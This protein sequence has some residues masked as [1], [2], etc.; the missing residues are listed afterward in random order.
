VRLLQPFEGAP[1]GAQT[2]LIGRQFEILTVVLF[3]LTACPTAHETS[4]IP[5]ILE[6]AQLD[7]QNSSTGRS[8]TSS[9]RGYRM[10]MTPA[11]TRRIKTSRM[12]MI[13]VVVLV[14]MELP[15]QRLGRMSD[16]TTP[17]T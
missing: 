11:T 6:P 5:S 7:D 3:A 12:M 9:I 15:F 8:P 13:I 10:V 17:Y 14:R 2:I 1:Q 4:L 16:A